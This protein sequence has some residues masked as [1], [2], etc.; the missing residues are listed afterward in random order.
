MAEKTHG[1]Y[2]KNKKTD[3]QLFINFINNFHIIYGTSFMVALW[4][5]NDLLNDFILIWEMVYGVK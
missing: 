4:I 2:K 5:L 1:C 3:Y